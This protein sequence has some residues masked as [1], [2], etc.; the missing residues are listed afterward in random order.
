MS[1]IR[2]SPSLDLKNIFNKK[3]IAVEIIDPM[4]DR[5][6][7]L[8][9]YPNK[10]KTFDIVIFSVPHKYFKKI[11]YSSFKKKNTIFDLDYV[12]DK[13]QI[14]KFREKKIKIYS[15]GDFSE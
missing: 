8:K 11:D 2:F 9:I 13:S 15:L 1:D 5:S 4:V 7:F 12:F 3:N 10:I 14:N 6:E